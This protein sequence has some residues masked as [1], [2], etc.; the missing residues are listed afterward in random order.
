MFWGCWTQYVN[1]ALCTVPV[2]EHAGLRDSY[3]ATHLAMPKL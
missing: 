3:G 2:C 1:D